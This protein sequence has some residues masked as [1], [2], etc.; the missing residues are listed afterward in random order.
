MRIV[1]DYF[2]LDRTTVTYDSEITGVGGNADAFY[3][4][5]EVTKGDGSL[6]TRTVVTFS[7]WEVARLLADYRSNHPLN[8]QAAPLQIP[9]PQSGIFTRICRYV[10]SLF[11]RATRSHTSPAP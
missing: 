8:R 6:A 5:A 9:G 3:V 4:V 11:R 7:H 2:G 1:R 10:A